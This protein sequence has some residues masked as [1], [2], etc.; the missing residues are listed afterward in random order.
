MNPAK[1]LYC[2]AFQIVFRAALP[3]LPY[4]NP[5]LLEG[6][7]AIIPILAENGVG[8]VMIVT[9]KGVHSLGLT[10][11]LETALASA[12]I[13]YTLFDKTVANP[14]TKNVEDAKERYLAEKCGAIIGFGGGS[15]MDCAKALGARIAR[16]KKPLSKMEGILK[17][18]RKIPLLIAVPT[19]AGTGSEATLA[20]VIVDSETRHKY[21]INDFP[22]IPKYA[23]L[24]AEITRSLPPFVTA[25]TGLDA[26]THATEAYIGRSTT[27]E[28]REQSMEAVK[29]IF[30]YLERAHTDGNDME[31]RHEMLKA[32]YLAGCAFTRSYV[33]Y[34]HAVAHSLGGKYNVPHGLANA[35]LLP[36][37][38]EDYGEAAYKKLHRLAIAAG[39]SEAGDSDEV[40]AK[41]FIF[42]VRELRQ[43]LNIPDKIPEIRRED[44]PELARKADAEGNPL[45][46]VPMLLDAKE[47]ERYYF[48]VMEEKTNDAC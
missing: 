40:G 20:A 44:I 43:K 10:N 17:V 42:A 41:K 9:D 3:I 26:L 19:T 14:T 8:R 33:G 4:R 21:P 36:F 1:K 45:Y 28:T 38:L 13:G 25:T 32:A 30:K 7:D 23:V 27:K 12:G 18:G 11:H 16:P 47:L 46:P 5:T 31:A 2:R 6:T 24:D 22:L 35:V 48:M 15:A 29:L 34:V 37:V 39:I